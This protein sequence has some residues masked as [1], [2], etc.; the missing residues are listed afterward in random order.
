MRNI[1]APRTISNNIVS[2]G[3]NLP[4]QEK[5]CPE[6]CSAGKNLARARFFLP[7]GIF[8]AETI[9]F[10]IVC[11]AEIILE[12]FHM[13]PDIQP[14]AT[15][16]ISKFVPRLRKGDAKYFRPANY[17]KQ[18]CFAGKKPARARKNLPRILFSWKKP[19]PGKIFPARRDFS[20]RN[21]IV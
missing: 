4:G 8:P 3:K 11:G 13:F 10:E 20:R 14:S 5:T 21:N 17:F 19:C 2:P 18:Y 12:I 6:Y 9:L 7:G 15:R 16:H 1:S